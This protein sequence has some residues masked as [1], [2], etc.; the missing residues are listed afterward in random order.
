[1]SVTVTRPK[2]GRT[3]ESIAL[4]IQATKLLARVGAGNCRLLV[5][6]AAGEAAGSQ[7]FTIEFESNE[8]YGIFSDKASVDPQLEALVEQLGAADS[9]A[10]VEFQGLINEIPVGGRSGRG[11]VIQSYI[12]RPTPGQLEAAIDLTRRAF[13]FLEKQGAV[14]TRLFQQTVAGSQS[15]TL[16]AAWEFETMQA[17]GKAGDAFMTDPKGIA[18]AQSIAQADAPVTVLNSAIYREVPLG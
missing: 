11:H 13:T 12:S 8:A 6:E 3:R 4:G 5:A 17:L 14:S 2:P 15:E 18:L 16:V 9:P 10:V 1:M 7:V